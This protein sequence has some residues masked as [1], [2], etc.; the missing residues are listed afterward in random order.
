GVTVP[1]AA[2]ALPEDLA[3]PLR[4]GYALAVVGRLE[5]GTLLLDL[6]S[7]APEDDDRL[8]AAVLAAV[9]EHA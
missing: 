4:R 8:T 5:R 9:A 6:R 3:P 7:V 1:S 2:V